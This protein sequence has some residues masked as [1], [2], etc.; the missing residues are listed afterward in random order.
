MLRQLRR[1]ATTLGLPSDGSVWRFARGGGF[2]ALHLPGAAPVELDVVQAALLARTCAQP[3][4]EERGSR[5]G[6]ERGGQRVSG[7]AR[8]A[9]SRAWSRA[10]TRSINRPTN[11]P[12][13][14]KGAAPHCER[15]LWAGGCA[16]AG[17]KGAHTERAKLRELVRLLGSER[18]GIDAIPRACAQRGWQSRAAQRR[19]GGG[20]VGRGTEC[21][22]GTSA[23][24]QSRREA[25]LA[26]LEQPR[27]TQHTAPCARSATRRA[28]LLT[29]PRAPTA[30]PN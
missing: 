21:G 30:T 28:E 18:V 6:T 22:G 16:N 9:W 7:A 25:R 15:K 14:Q 27:H 2:F 29:L 24:G 5:T 1:P 8:R 4:G 13:D 11:Q 10:F 26:P 20:R 17:R 23:G 12:A 3:R 19:S